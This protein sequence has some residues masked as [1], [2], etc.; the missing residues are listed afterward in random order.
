VGAHRGTWG[1]RRQGIL[2]MEGS[3]RE[4]LLWELYEGAL[5]MGHPS[6]G[7]PFGNLGSH[8]LGVMEVMKGRL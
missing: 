3:G 6:V 1:I 5:G 8:L 7:A 2:E 4:H